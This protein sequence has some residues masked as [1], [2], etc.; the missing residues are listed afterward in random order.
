MKTN[1]SF[2][3][4][5]DWLSAAILLCSI[6]GLLFSGSCKKD[7]IALSCHDPLACDYRC[8]PWDTNTPGGIDNEF[9]CYCLYSTAH[10]YISSLERIE[11]GQAI[12]LDTLLFSIDGE[13]TDFAQC[14]EFGQ[15]PAGCDS[16]CGATFQFL[17][18][19]SLIIWEATMLWDNGSISFRRDTLR[20]SPVFK[21]LEIKVL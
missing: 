5:K 14:V 17:N 19:S 1:F 15:T 6:A 7:R 12:R 20:A 21:C 10:F 3:E 2:L 8:I 9:D 13:P 16:F 4:K 18:G 11:N